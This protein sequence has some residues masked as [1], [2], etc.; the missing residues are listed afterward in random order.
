MS[1]KTQ[2]NSKTVEHLHGIWFMSVLRTFSSDLCMAHAIVYNAHVHLMVDWT[3]FPTTRVNWSKQAKRSC[4]F[5]KDATIT[6]VWNKEIIVFFHPCQMM[7]MWLAVEVSEQRS[8]SSSSRFYFL[9]ASLI[10]SI[11]LDLWKEGKKTASS[12]HTVTESNEQLNRPTMTEQLC[13]QNCKSLWK[14]NQPLFM[15]LLFSWIIKRFFSVF[16]M[17]FRD[18]FRFSQLKLPFSLAYHTKLS[19][20]LFL[21]TTRIEKKMYAFCHFTL[22]ICKLFVINKAESVG[23]I[24]AT[25]TISCRNVRANRFLSYEHSSNALES[26][27]AKFEFIFCKQSTTVLFVK[28]KI[29]NA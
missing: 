2:G 14:Q 13:S 9:N 15:N 24:R 25:V 4:I 27:D 19:W 5:K 6:C 28:N 11:Q 22:K 7:L 3:H 26:V 16:Y 23:V 29:I 20:E 18:L 21:K 17:I 8:W 1:N 10:G 12:A